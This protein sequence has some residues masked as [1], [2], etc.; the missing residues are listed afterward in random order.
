MS[1]GGAARNSAARDSAAKDGAGAGGGAGE[2][3]VG[4]A[5][6]KFRD[7][8]AADG[9]ELD[10]SLGD[11]NRVTIRIV[12]GPDACADCLVPLP[13]MEAIMSDALGPTPYALDHIELPAHT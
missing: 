1:D 13:V 3:V 11:A 8:L 2:E 10:W 12:A 7:V 5:L 6:Q 9:Y 4:T